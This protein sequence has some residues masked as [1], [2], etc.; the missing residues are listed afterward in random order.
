ML[1][2][3]VW[4]LWNAQVKDVLKTYIWHICACKFCIKVVLFHSISALLT[5]ILSILHLYRR[6]SQLH[7]FTSGKDINQAQ[8]RTFKGSLC[9]AQHTAKYHRTNIAVG[10]LVSSNHVRKYRNQTNQRHYLRS[11][12]SFRMGRSAIFIPSGSEVWISSNIAFMGSLREP[13]AGP[14]GEKQCCVQGRGNSMAH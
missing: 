4:K 6:T 5:E 12:K 1:K 10:L 7:Q 13:A 2:T 14:W 8:E 3:S 9:L 11:G